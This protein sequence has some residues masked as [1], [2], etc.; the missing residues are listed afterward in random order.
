MASAVLSSD[1]NKYINPINS[2]FL[3][4]ILFKSFNKNALLKHR[5][6]RFLTFEPPPIQE[7]DVT[8][9]NKRDAGERRTYG[10]QNQGK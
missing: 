8:N 4:K 2:E 9:K 7:M 5:I 3:K 10:Y 1:G 6:E